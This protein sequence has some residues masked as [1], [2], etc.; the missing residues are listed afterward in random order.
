M[1]ANVV[2]ATVALVLCLVLFYIGHANADRIVQI[3]TACDVWRSCLV[4]F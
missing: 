4:G 3:H 2:P 1:P